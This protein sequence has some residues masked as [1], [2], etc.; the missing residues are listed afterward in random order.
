MPIAAEIQVLP[1]EPV[2]AAGLLQWGCFAEHRAS[3]LGYLVIEVAWKDGFR[4]II[5]Y[6][7]FSMRIEVYT[8][9]C[10]FFIR[11]GNARSQLTATEECVEWG[12]MWVKFEARPA[13]L[14][15]LPAL[16]GT[17]ER[18]QTGHQRV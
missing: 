7:L 1:H 14:R 16:S 17:G 2:L 8:T 3:R 18:K 11:N 9:M 4:C 10:L 15:P 6:L 5:P 12:S 13:Q